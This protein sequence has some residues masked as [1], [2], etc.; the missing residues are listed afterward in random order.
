[1][2][3][4]HFLKK[5]LKMYKIDFILVIFSLL[6]ISILS[7]I[8]SLL[9]KIIFD[10]MIIKK[11]LFGIVL[12]CLLI[13]TVYGMKSLLNYFSLY[14]INKFSTKIITSIRND[15]TKKLLSLPLEFFDLNRP[16]Y[17]AARVSE[18]NNLMQL[19]S[20]SSIKCIINV[21]E[22]IGAIVIL[23]YLNIELTI[24]LL[25]IT[26]LFFFVSKHFSSSL[27]K[28][29][30]MTLENSSNLNGMVQQTFRKIEE[31]KNLSI[32]NKE[33]EELKNASLKFMNSSL[34]QANSIATCT[35]LLSFLGSFSNVI[36]L[37]CGAMFIIESKLSIGSYMTFST[38]LGRVYA[39]IQSVSMQYVTLSTSLI[40]MDRIIE[41]MEEN[42]EQ[43][44]D[45][46]MVIAGNLSE[47]K[48][49]DV[50]F[51]YKNSKN[52]VLARQNF[53][54]HS[55]DKVRIIGPNGSGKT[56]ILRLLLCLYK[57]QQGKIYFNGLDSLH[58]NKYKL[59]S[60][61]SIISQKI[62]LFPGTIKENLKY[63]LDIEEKKFDN[64]L[65]SKDMKLILKNIDLNK[66]IYDETSLSG[67]QIQRI[68]I[69][70]GIVRNADVFLFDE[71]MSNLDVSGKES[72]ISLIQE[73]LKNK[74]C[75]FIEH[76]DKL[77]GIC[78]KTIKL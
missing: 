14:K 50:S 51:K 6:L 1:M 36:L 76:D 40:S 38:L 42:P 55:K 19:F 30:K 54:I 73:I 8:P 26:P 67:G 4:I 45:S 69:A 33:S 24:V 16:G 15:V 7:L 47:I 25:L 63:G 37:F 3:R 56:T 32:E 53:E 58:V 59:R 23:F 27:K 72:M 34:S 68:A 71:S 31:I 64:L 2:K 78:N 18:V 43:T 39:P 48:F 28:N 74:I 22:F 21:L 11:N 5:Y 20:Q 12:I 66:T 9:I 46:G 70:R 61:I 57:P 75:I 77:I 62:N 65:L 52:W 17:V 10:N 49:V 60:K 29:T 35:E 44:N 41:F 13:A